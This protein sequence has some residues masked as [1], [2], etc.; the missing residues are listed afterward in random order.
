MNILFTSPPSSRVGRFSTF[1]LRHACI[2]ALLSNVQKDFDFV[3]KYSFRSPSM[4]IFKQNNI[5]QQSRNKNSKDTPNPCYWADSNGYFCKKHYLA[6]SSLLL[7][8]LNYCSKK[9]K[10][11]TK[12]WL[13]FPT[14]Q[15]YISNFKNFP[16]TK[17]SQKTEKYFW[18]TSTVRYLDLAHLSGFR[19]RPTLT[20]IF[21]PP[22]PPIFP[23]HSFPPSPPSPPP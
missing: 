21:L 5:G 6:T 13:S 23:H 2:F 16:V 22:F 20:S 15:V 1:S 10:W 12:V 4:F 9:I 8:L 3:P 14:L 7:N 18:D 19:N 17:T 11:L